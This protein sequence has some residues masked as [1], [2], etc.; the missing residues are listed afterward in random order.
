MLFYIDPGTGSMLF[1]ILIGAAGAAVYAFRSLRVKLKG[2]LGGGRRRHGEDSAVPFV[3]FTDSGRYWTIF[4]PLCDEMEKRGETVHYLTASPDDPLL[5][6]K[7]EHVKTEFI[8]EGNR[9]FARMNMLRADVVL[10]STPG[11]DVYQWKRSPEV[12]WYVHVLHAASGVTTYRMFGTDY[13]D[14]LLLSGENQIREVRSLEALRHLPPKECVLAGLPHMDAIRER[15]LQRGP[16][17][18]HETTVLLAPSWGADSLLNRF[19][20]KMIGSLRQTGYHL[21]IRPHPQSMTSEKEMIER[22]RKLFPEEEGLEWNF[23]KDNFEALYRSDLLISDYSSVV[24]DYALIFDRPV[25]YAD[26]SLDPEPY[27]AGWLDGE[28]WIL[29]TLPRIGTRLTEENIGKLPELIE[30]SLHSQAFAEGRR[31]AA[32]EA[33]VHPGESVRLIADYLTEVRR[34]LTEKD[35]KND[36]K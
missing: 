17:P 20:E 33:W 35:E 19:G 23:D 31:R 34:R 9:A 29:R 3:F 26:V 10:S 6:E 32:E 14:A 4:K 1:T 11:L 8:G 15:W 25:I 27:D 18:A 24:F 2:L 30:E 22:L 5:N 21:I 13:Y 36:E 16:A 12:R 7:Y 28:M